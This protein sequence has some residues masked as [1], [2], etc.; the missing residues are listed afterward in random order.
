MCV[1]GKEEQREWEVRTNE[2]ARKN[3]L[4]EKAR[5]AKKTSV[6]MDP[7]GEVLLGTS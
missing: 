5:G 7:E 2:G 1:R 3:M 4:R 6:N